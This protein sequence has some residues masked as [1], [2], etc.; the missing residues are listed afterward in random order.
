MPMRSGFYFN[1]PTPWGVG[2]ETAFRVVMSE[3]ISIHPLRGEWDMGLQGQHGLCVISIH[4][5]R[6]EWDYVLTT[7]RTVTRHFNPPTPWGVGRNNKRSALYHGRFQST[8]SVGSGTCVVVISFA[9]TEIS[10]HPLRGEWDAG[11][12]SHPAFLS[13]FNPPTPWGVGR[14][15]KH[16]RYCQG[17]FQST[18]SVGSGTVRSSVTDF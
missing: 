10:I 17:R 15:R 18:H 8:H 12:M 9:D 2:R 7:P 6:G 4:P 14:G 13:N 1:P 5:L 11:C 3:D 16:L